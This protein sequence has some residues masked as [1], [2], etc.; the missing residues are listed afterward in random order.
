MPDRDPWIRFALTFAALAVLSELIYYGVAL[1]S[2]LFRAYLAVLA[3]VSGWLL[4]LGSTRSRCA[5]R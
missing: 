2:P 3:R 1:E 5:A 4:S